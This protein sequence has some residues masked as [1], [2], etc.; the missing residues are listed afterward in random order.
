MS[1]IRRRDS[2]L[3]RQITE[4]VAVARGKNAAINH[5]SRLYTEITA[6]ISVDDHIHRIFIINS[7]VTNHRWTSDVGN[8]LYTN[9]YINIKSERYSF[10]IKY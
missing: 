5:N 6:T 8:V 9:T 7:T 2:F 3:R 1:R 10:L 4:S